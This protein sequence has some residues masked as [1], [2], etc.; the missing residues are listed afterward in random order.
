MKQAEGGNKTTKIRICSVGIFLADVWMHPI[1][2]DEA[3]SL[4]NRMRCRGYF[5]IVLAGKDL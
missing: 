5:E 3:C 1:A 2:G 4:M